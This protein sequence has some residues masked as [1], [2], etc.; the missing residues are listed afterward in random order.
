MT[1]EASDMAAWLMYLIFLLAPV[2][3]LFFIMAG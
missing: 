2:V 1:M 3:M